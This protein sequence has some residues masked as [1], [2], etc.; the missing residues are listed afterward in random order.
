MGEYFFD[1]GLLIAARSNYEEVLNHQDS[2]WYD[3]A[4][5]KIAWVDINES[6]FREAVE[7][8]QQVV[9]NM[10]AAELRGE[11]LRFEMRPQ[12]INDM[13]VAWTEIE[14]GWVEA[15][16]Y[17]MEHEGEEIMR[18]K[19]LAMADLYDEKGFD[20]QRV[21]VMEWFIESYPNDGQMAT[22]MEFVA[23]SLTKIG[24]WNRYEDRVREYVRYLDPNGTWAIVNTDD[25]QA[26]TNARIFA[27]NAF[28]GVISRN[29]EEAGRLSRQELY[30]EVA[31]DYAEFFRRWPDSE[32]AYEQRFFYA[33][34]LYYNIEDHAG[35]GDQYL[36]V[37]RM[38]HEGEHAYDSAVG[39]LQAF[40]DLMAAE[41]PGI[42][43]ELEIMSSDEIRQMQEQGLTELE[44]GQWSARYV[45][46][47]E[48]F[49]ELYPADD[50]IPMA[51]WRAAEIF[52]R[53]NRLGEAANRF[54]SIIEH[55]PNHRFADDAAISAFLCYQY[56]ENWE[57]IEYWARF[58]LAHNPEG[59]ADINADSLQQ[60]IAFSI[61]EQTQDLLEAG[62]EFAAAELMISLYNEFPDSEFSPLALYNAAAIYERARR[63]HTA[64]ETYNIF[65]N[66]YPEHENVPEA[67]FT[68]GLVFDSQ[69]EFAEAA[70]WFEEVDTHITDRNLTYEE[71]SNAV[72]NAAR[73][74]EALSEFDTAIAHYEHYMVLEP[75]AEIIPNLHFLLAEIERDRGNLDQS[76]DRYGVF[77][78]T[79]TELRSQ[80]LAATVIQARIRD[81]QGR[82]GDVM[83][84]YES[85]FEQFG[86]GVLLF[87]ESGQPTEWESQ[88][89]WQIEESDGRLAALPYAAEAAFHIADELYETAQAIGLEYPDGRWRVLSENL[90]NR[91]EAL[92]AAQRAMFEIYEMGDAAWSVAAT[93]RIG[94]LYQQFYNDM[95]ELPQFDIDQCLDDGFGYDQCDEADQT[96]ST[97]FY[98]F[99]YPIETKAQEALVQALSTA[100]EFG[101]Y[102]EWTE[103][104]VER[105]MEVD[106]SIRVR[107]EEGVEPGYQGALFSTT[108]YITDLTEKL[109]Q[110]Q[111]LEEQR[112]QQ[113][114]QP[115]QPGAVPGLDGTPETPDV[116]DVPG[117][118][119]AEEAVPGELTSEGEEAD[120]E[121]VEGE[122]EQ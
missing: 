18:R 31:D 120:G 54:A 88:P 69:A 118:D 26:L 73:L 46:V 34:I 76:F 79:F 43:D 15:R 98:E 9:T 48:L 114:L 85:A 37:V 20:E 33:E 12:A 105:M 8:F 102:T 24:N 41:V 40:D 14:N 3:F 53:A 59:S 42:G 84:L 107:G 64:V 74:R 17:L 1:N 39:A 5:Y 61:N 70:H 65:L 32:E 93:T 103:Y 62:E 101:V 36:E 28:L 106:N 21:A 57:R 86:A 60:A 23:D 63:V 81:E 22:W 51:S 30:Q 68:L 75:E 29:Y 109:E 4:I 99:M 92:D 94:E 16:Q 108:A 71:H 11:E 122:T 113:Q 111:I 115:G 96:I 80:R 82:T 89:G 49:T 6:R 13:L 77:R 35:A 95:Y 90:Q 47:V 83:D 25:A 45:E 97:M 121:D 117:A 44:L 7:G 52:R 100:H 72:F 56:D 19:L 110:M 112:Q 116:P 87:D 27:H 119:E 91:G 104:A 78:D 50:L 10:D 2:D 55:H 67:M 58:L 66:A 38:D